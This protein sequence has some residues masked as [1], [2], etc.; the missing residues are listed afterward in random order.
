MKIRVYYYDYTM[1]NLPAHLVQNFGKT[2]FYVLLGPKLRYS[3]NEW[4]CT[5]SIMNIRLQIRGLSTQA[6]KGGA[7][8]ISASLPPAVLP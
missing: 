7:E 3:G 4:Y 1:Y 8:T 6:R 5:V 2:T